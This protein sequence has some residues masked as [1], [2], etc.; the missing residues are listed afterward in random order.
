MAGQLI[1]GA[2][3]LMHAS[4]LLAA[5]DM[6]TYQVAQPLKTHWRSATCEEVDCPNWLNGWRVRVEGLYPWLL[7][8]AMSSGRKWTLLDVAAAESYLVFEAGQPCFA[9]ST[10]RMLVGRPQRH[11]ERGG[12]WRGNPRGERRELNAADWLDS[13]ANHQDRI[14]TVIGRG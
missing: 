13:F 12:D 7:Q 9:A 6:K 8:A 11:F 1:R 5:H 4:P 3:G 14:A 10:H 2:D